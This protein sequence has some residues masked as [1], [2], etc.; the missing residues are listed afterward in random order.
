L[1]KNIPSKRSA[2]PGTARNE[3]VPRQALLLA[4]LTVAVFSPTL[5]SGFVYDS[6]L[7]ILTDPFIHTAANWWNVLSFRVLGMDVL[8]FNRP[9][10][11]AVLMFD[12]AVWGANPFGYHLT[13]ILLHAANT[14]LLFLV[15]RK[16]LAVG[17]LERPAFPVM[18]V[19]F[20]G[21]LLFGVHPIM[22]EAVCEPCYREDLLVVFFSVSA[23]LLAI[24][25]RNEARGADI[26]RAC[27]CAA[28]CLLAV[29]SKET[30]IVAP[31]L[32]LFYWI[33]LRRKDRPGFW[34]VAVSL[35]GILV[36]LFLWLRFYLAPEHSVIFESKPGYPGGSFTSAMAL[37]PRILVL[38]LQNFVWPAG[39]CADYGFRSIQHLDPVFCIVL[40]GA[41]VA[42]CA[43]AA[44]RSPLLIL[45]F[46][47]I[48][49]PLLPVANLIPIY[50]AAADRYL[51]FSMVGV[52]MTL[53]FFCGLTFPKKPRWVGITGTWV[54]LLALAVYALINVERQ[55]VWA[56]SFALWQ[57]TFQ[58]NPNSST[59]AYGLGETL[60]EMGSL[61]E[62][63]KILR[64]ANRLFGGSDG[65]TLAIL[66]VVLQR[67]GREEESARFLELALKA[68]PHL[69]DPDKRVAALALTRPE[70]EAI[71]KLLAGHPPG[72]AGHPQDIRLDLSTGQL[73]PL[74]PQ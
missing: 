46:L 17:F 47:A 10:H 51:Y 66:A 15:I 36:A 74:P 27:L 30:G 23:L 62:S 67:L 5:W 2:P 45:G 26:L 56:D 25:H 16:L 58:R 71:K 40:I 9:V 69:S 19:P 13:S 32:L 38:Y 29:G 43:L 20:L 37:L 50:R 28:S 4:A 63:E 61:E 22:T 60:W 53:A 55:K 70:A 6:R 12:S 14:V 54:C 24:G 65:D 21:A 35:A 3:H 8:D 73:P 31:L 1:K 57:D 39:L 68:N 42:S 7:Q 34:F 44:R 11:L 41:L 49:L 59:A 72:T 48:V 64:K 52:A 33:L 18:M